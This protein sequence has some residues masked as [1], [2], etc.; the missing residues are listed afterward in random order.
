M[1]TTRA[2]RPRG[3]G[4]PSPASLPASGRP[5]PGGGWTVAPSS[6][7]PA[8]A[9][10]ARP[11]PSSPQAADAKPTHSHS[12]RRSFT[13]FPPERRAH[14]LRRTAPER[15]A[16]RDRGRIVPWAKPYEKRAPK[17]T[18]ILLL[19]VATHSGPRRH[20]TAKGVARVPERAQV[21]RRP[22][23]AARAACR[24]RRRGSGRHAGERRPGHARGRPSSCRP[25]R[26]TAR[27]PGH[28][29]GPTGQ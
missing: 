25:P 20:R 23:P 12:A 6:P 22:R 19:Q 2:V 27:A 1:L 28:A 15:R 17:R 16:P 7:A 24:A 13:R 5:P 26:R 3:I 9:A 14:S 4:V 18:R 10:L 8:S 11:G 21:L 29:R